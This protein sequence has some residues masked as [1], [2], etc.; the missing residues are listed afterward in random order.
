MLWNVDLFFYFRGPFFQP[1]TFFPWPF[2]SWTFFSEHLAK[3]SSA[4]TFVH[5]ELISLLDN[6]AHYIYFVNVSI[7]ALK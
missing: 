6:N 3:R 5:A 2:F 7:F 1:W 4:S